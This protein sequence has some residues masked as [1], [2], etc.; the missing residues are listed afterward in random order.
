MRDIACSAA[1]CFEAASLPKR[2]RRSKQIQQADGTRP[3]NA[4]GQRQLSCDARCG[5]NLAERNGALSPSLP[6]PALSVG[7]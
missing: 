3:V 4:A 6:L 7:S 2:S 1:L 5:M